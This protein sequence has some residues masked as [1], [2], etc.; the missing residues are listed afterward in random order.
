MRGQGSFTAFTQYVQYFEDGFSNAANIWLQI[1]QTL[2]S[3]GRFVQLLERKPSIPPGCGVKPRACEGSLEF[4]AV[5]FRYPA[6][7]LT[8]SVLTRFDLHAPAGGVVALVGASGA[9]KSTIAR[10][11]ER[12]Y[13]PTDGAILLDGRDYRTLD[14]RWLR[15]RIGF[16]EQEPTLFDRSIED[17]VRYGKPRAA[18]AEV[19]RAP[20][21][22]APA[23]TPRHRA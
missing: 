12:F 16:V 9:G 21:P 7:P 15:R 23:R 22:G 4:R 8:S 3:A 17:N 6:T 10:L 13:D 19:S 11:I 18:H 20:Q 2:I 1:R 14:V 5:C